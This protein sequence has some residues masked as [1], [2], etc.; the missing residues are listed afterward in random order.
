MG[1]YSSIRDC[2]RPATAVFLRQYPLVIRLE[3]IEL[4][5]KEG[6]MDGEKREEFQ[7]VWH[8]AAVIERFSS[9]LYPL[10]TL[11]LLKQLPAIGYV[12]PELV[13][14]GTPEE[15][16]PIATKG[17]IEI[18]INQ[19]NK[20]IGVRGRNAQKAVESFKELREFYLERLD[21]SPGLAT[22]Y[23]EF[24]G[25]GWAKSHANPTDVC[26]RF[27]S[28]HAALKGLG[29]ALGMSATNFGLQLVPPNRDP[30]DPEW[31]HVHIEPQVVS[32]HK[33]YRVRW[34]WRSSDAA[35]LLAKLSKVDE[36]LKKLIS[37][38]ESQ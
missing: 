14:R 7:V 12:V 6:R 28:D 9:V 19:D 31:F 38:I 15:G 10:D 8:Q 34:I 26:S 16:K 20:T 4:V 24:D 3:L 11:E 32:S 37:K 36:T 1:G 5:Q 18:L 13:L 29:K 22:H 27:W 33:R 35:E 17:D 25:Q 30:N 21:P 2:E 23:L